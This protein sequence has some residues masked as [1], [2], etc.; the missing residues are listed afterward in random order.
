M[1]AIPHGCL[2]PKNTDGR[3]GARPHRRKF[4]PCGGLRGGETGLGGRRQHDVI[5]EPL[6]PFDGLTPD[7]LL[8]PPV[9]EVHAEIG[10]RLLSGQV[11]PIA[12][13]AG[14]ERY[15]R[16]SDACR[17]QLTVEAIAR[18]V[19]FVADL[20]RGRGYLVIATAI[21]SFDATRLKSS[22]IREY[23][24]ATRRGVGGGVRGHP[25]PEEPS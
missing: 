5:D 21:L 4:G 2:F 24:E 1:L 13:P 6:E 16:A 19:G 23:N 14:R 22:L 9:E 3:R 18:R 8:V 12:G 11:D 10:I 17:G 25:T 7:L 20:Q 15:H